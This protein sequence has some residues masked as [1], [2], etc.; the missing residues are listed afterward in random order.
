MKYFNTKSDFSNNFYQTYDKS[1]RQ[2]KFN[3]NKFVNTFKDTI[4]ANSAEIR[5]VIYTAQNK[6]DNTLF[7]N[8]ARLNEFPKI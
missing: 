7:K 4:P 2:R 6:R 1:V 8:A 3:S 5:P